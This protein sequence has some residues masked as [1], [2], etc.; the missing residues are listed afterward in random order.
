MRD[1]PAVS[2]ID[3]RL[4]TDVA[5][6]LSG[7]GALAY[8]DRQLWYAVCGRLESPQLTQG[9]AQIV[10]GIILVAVGVAVGILATVFVAVLVPVGMVVTGIGVQNRRAER[11]RPST[12]ALA[13]SY[14]TFVRE[15]LVPLRERAP[16]RLPGLLPADGLPGAAGAATGA[17]AAGGA[18][19]VVCD[20]GE[21]AALLSALA[22]AAPPT[23]LAVVEA[24]AGPLLGAGRV[25]AVH[26]ADPRG[27]ALPLRLAAAGAAEVVDI[28]L[29]P[30]QLGGRHV[31]VIEGAPYLI[32]S[33][34]S[35][36][37]TPD[38]VVW[39]AGG[40]RVELAVLGS[41]ALAEALPR[42]LAAPARPL[43]GRG[44]GAVALAGASLLAP[45][46]AAEADPDAEPEADP[47]G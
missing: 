13:V 4:V 47:Q 28:G 8:T 34:L 43:P 21:T 31:Q 3:E 2:P 12:R 26:D 39:L 19:V 22:P 35:T 29:R 1:C 46:P 44:G 20:R 45:S 15:T 36:V 32:G 42:A 16:G 38:E 7:P 6:D 40:R 33:E 37:L 17:T 11:N 30:G 41:A 9:L 14:D 25:H 18:A 5:R 24:D 27:C 23:W 10:A